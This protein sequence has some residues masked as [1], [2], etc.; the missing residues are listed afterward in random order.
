MYNRLSHHTHA[1]ILVPEKFGIGEGVSTE[2]TAFKPTDD[3]LKSI[4]QKMHVGG[5]FW[6]SKSL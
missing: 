3:V 1:N 5:I 2:D 6:F 4:N